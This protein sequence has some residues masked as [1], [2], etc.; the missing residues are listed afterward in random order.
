MP[1][2][3]PPGMLIDPRSSPLVRDTVPGALSRDEETWVPGPNLSSNLGDALFLSF[4]SL[5]S[6]ILAFD[7]FFLLSVGGICRPER[8]L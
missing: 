2:V 8:T 1:C 5:S 4:C 6:L 7:L 3:F